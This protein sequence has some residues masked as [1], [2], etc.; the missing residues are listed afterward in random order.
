MI[1]ETPAFYHA[2]VDLARYIAQ[3]HPSAARRFLDAV[4]ATLE[5]IHD[6]PNIGRAW[7]HGTIPGLRVWRVSGFPNHLIF[8]RPIP[9]GIEAVDLIHGARDLDTPLPE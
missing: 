7:R 2:S 5:F 4:F 8:Y 3:D 1:V 6:T 9:E